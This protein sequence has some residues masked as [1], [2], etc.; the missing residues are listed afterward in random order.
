MKTTSWYIIAAAAI[1]IL[2]AVSH[3]PAY[4]TMTAAAMT[5]GAAVV[6]LAAELKKRA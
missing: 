3:A 4:L 6:A 2:A 5:V 1:T